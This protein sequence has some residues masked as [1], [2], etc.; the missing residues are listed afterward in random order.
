MIFFSGFLAK[1]EV[2]KNKLESN[3]KKVNILSLYIISSKKVRLLKSK[4]SFKCFYFKD[5]ALKMK[6]QKSQL[7][8]SNRLPARYE[9][10]ALPGELSWQY[11][12]K[13]RKFI[14][15]DSENLQIVSYH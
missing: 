3:K 1:Q 4:Y 14:F 10:A 15:V 13:C 9:G 8:D 7:S 6:L 2:K 5:N 12:L 11:Q